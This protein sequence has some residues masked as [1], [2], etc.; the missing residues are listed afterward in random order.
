MTDPQRSRDY[1]VGYGKPPKHTQFQKGQSGNPRGRQKGSTSLRATLEKLLR[2][3]VPVKQ[4]GQ[5]RFMSQLEVLL[6]QLCREAMLGK[7]RAMEQVLRLIK[8]LEAHQQ[9]E[10]A[11]AEAPPRG[12]LVV[13]ATLT[14]EEWLKRYG[15]KFPDEVD[16]KGDLAREAAAKAKEPGDPPDG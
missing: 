2:Q 6:S 10:A 3:R 8:D 11:A 12:V 16:W 7:P 9:V 14:P 1:E 4:D 15:P 5:M 13:P